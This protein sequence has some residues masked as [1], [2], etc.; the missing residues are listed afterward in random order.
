MGTPFV[1]FVATLA[2]KWNGEDFY[3]DVEK[4]VAE[5]NKRGGSC[6]EESFKKYLRVHGISFV[7]RG[8]YRDTKNILRKISQ[9]IIDEDIPMDTRKSLEPLVD[10]AYEKFR[11]I[12]E[13]NP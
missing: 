7:K 13:N 12:E 6:T 10:A 9:E 2:E 8:I 4:A 11:D 1:R 3:L 5:W